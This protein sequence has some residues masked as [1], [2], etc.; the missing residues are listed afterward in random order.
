MNLIGVLWQANGSARVR[1]GATDV[2]AS[3]KVSIEKS[4]LFSYSLNDSF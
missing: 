1:L 4:L 3:I 2:I